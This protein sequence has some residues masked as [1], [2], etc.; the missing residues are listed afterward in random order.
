MCMDPR[1]FNLIDWLQVV[2]EIFFLGS[3]D[4]IPPS[5]YFPVKSIFTPGQLIGRSVCQVQGIAES[6]ILSPMLIKLNFTECVEHL[7]LSSTIKQRFHH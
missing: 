5:I 2:V 6:P 7:H 1:T 3:L 4:P